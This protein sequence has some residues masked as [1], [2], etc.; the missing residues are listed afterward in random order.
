MIVNILP[1][2]I[3]PKEKTLKI[4]TA[5]ISSLTIKLKQKEKL[6]LSSVQNE[7]CLENVIKKTNKTLPF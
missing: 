4:G 6:F 1:T 2:F 7:N 5:K 3:L